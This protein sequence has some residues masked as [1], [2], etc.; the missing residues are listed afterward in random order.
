[1]DDVD[2][3]KEQLLQELSALRN[4]IEK[5]R[6]SERENSEGRTFLEEAEALYRTA[7]E[8]FND[9]V[10]IL[11][12]N[13]RLY[14]NKKYLEILG[15]GSH[16]EVSEKPLFQLVHPDDRETVAEYAR[17]RQE[18]EG[19][20]SSYE[21]RLI[22]KD[23]STVHVAISAST[24]TY[25]GR[26]ASLG[27]ISD[28]TEQKRTQ[29]RFQKN[30]KFLSGLIEHS[31]ALIFV[32]DREGRYELVN[33]K[34]EEVTG[35]GRRD[36][37]G[38]TD[39]ELFPGPTGE[40]FRRNDLE[41]MGSGLV[42]E[43][44]EV[45]EDE[46]GKRFF[47][48]I[49]F[50]LRGH[51][52]AV[53]GVCG[54]VTEITARKEM[55]EK[56][57]KSESLMRAITDS[58]RDA[59]L[60]MDA[61]GRISFWNPAAEHIF[62]YTREEAIGRELHRFL[63]P[64]RFLKMYTA[65]FERFRSTGQ[66]RAA[67][68]TVELQ[69]L[70]NN[71]EEFPIELSLSAIKLEDGWHSVGI[72]RDI[73]ER[74]RAEEDLRASEKKYRSVIENIQDVFY[75][76]DASGLLLMGSPSGARMFGYD[77]ADE[78]IGLLLDDFWVDP[79]GRLQLIDQIKAKGSVK[80]FEAVLKKK[81]GTTFNASLTTQFYYDDD[82]NFL[83]TEGIIRDITDR[84]LL[85]TQLLQAH[86]MEAI[87]TL[88]GGIAHDFNNLLMGIQGYASLMLYGMDPADPH[89][90]KLKNIEEI[91]SKGSD[92]TG[93][94]LGFA[95][96]GKYEVKSADING[97]IARTADMFGRTRK[98]IVMHRDLARNLPDVEID[99]GQIE[100]VF[101][102][103]YLNAW[104]AMP[105]GGD[106][107]LKTEIVLLE[108]AHTM[109]YSAMPGKYVKVTVSDTGVGMD[110]TTQKRI[111]EPFFTTKE[112]GRGSGLGLA[113]AYGVIKNHGGI[114][115]VSS[116][117]GRGTTFTIYLPVTE[118]GHAREKGAPVSPQKGSG[119]ILVVDD[120][121]MLLE[122]SSEMLRMLGYNVITADSGQRAVDLYEGRKDTIDL[123]ILDMIM[124]GLS[125]AATYDRLKEI[126]PGVKVILS[127]GYSL[128]GEASH[129]LER[130]CSGFIQKPFSMETLSKK[131][132]EILEGN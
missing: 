112:M 86:K 2:K 19:A 127:S 12:G 122:T 14:C 20:P 58:A 16:E 15:Y 109:R 11:A 59:I 10:I 51:D 5:L 103:L 29:E 39:E 79:A 114:I 74:R 8:H 63:A 123:V 30:S 113:S 68:R 89:F 102:N 18:G 3:T 120:Q 50:P 105:G 82:G 96:G 38:K 44:E 98:E 91:V 7:I 37:I 84:K 78:M 41:V 81:D 48:S 22:K 40:Q 28:I 52:E 118:K 47:I 87:G 83:G 32:K 33:R 23:G 57:G 121:E 104:Q 95:Q 80:D 110:D 129:I 128:D 90:Q 88:A 101:V 34:W 17:R 97:L 69:A 100:Q 60:M 73:T 108:K 115:E 77:S 49:K 27:F 75:R 107:Y 45:L 130:G 119:T 66:G 56:L 126:C 46:K 111:F 62:G 131:V 85:E 6:I 99:Q 61:G 65:V 94:L 117:R 26:P 36:V 132:K 43:K 93:Q 72:I 70:R 71:G 24:I 64:E 76:S 1:M 21:C 4:Q 67:G 35:L 54:M 124:P 25:K 116:E 106:I 55:E 125:G 42:L 9:G 53:T 13:E 92:L 31:G